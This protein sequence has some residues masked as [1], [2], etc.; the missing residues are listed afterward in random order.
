M[1]GVLPMIVKRFVEGIYKI[2]FFMF[3]F[4]LK[5]RQWKFKN[6]EQKGKLFAFY[7]QNSFLRVLYIAR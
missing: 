5:N 2:K 3:K 4:I 6:R 1:K 7:L